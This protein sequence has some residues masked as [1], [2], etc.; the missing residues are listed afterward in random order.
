MAVE[1]VQAVDWFQH[2]AANGASQI[3]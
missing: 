2:Q 1:K 3:K